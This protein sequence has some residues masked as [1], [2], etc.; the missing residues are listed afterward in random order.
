[1][2]VARLAEVGKWPRLAGVALVAKVTKVKMIEAETVSN[3]YCKEDRSRVWH[4]FV[5]NISMESYRLERLCAAFE[6]KEKQ[7]R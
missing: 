2:L 4:L 7:K 1:M 6:L 3:F 5:L